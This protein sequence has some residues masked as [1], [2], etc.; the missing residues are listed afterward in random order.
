MILVQGYCEKGHKDAAGNPAQ[1]INGPTGDVC[2]RCEADALPKTGTVSKTEDPGDEKMRQMLAAAGVSVPKASAGQKPISLQTAK[3]EKLVT[4]V[5][6]FE[7]RV[8]QALEI[9]KSLP[10]PS[11]VKQFKAV[12]K[13][14]AGMES[15]LEKRNDA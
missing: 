2:L 7:D 5:E 11:D 12:H 14:I 15:L 1:K 8:R 6:S 9:M 13:I 10:M 3:A 4:I